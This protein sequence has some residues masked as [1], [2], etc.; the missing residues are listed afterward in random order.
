MRMPGQLAAGADGPGLHLLRFS[1]WVQQPHRLVGTAAYSAAARTR[2]RLAG[3]VRA[4]FNTV[5]TVK[6]GF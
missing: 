6:S 5:D 1:A 3:L 2:L 4:I